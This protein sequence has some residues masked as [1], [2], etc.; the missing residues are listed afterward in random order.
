MADDDGAP[1]RK[2]VHIIGQ[3]L[4]DLSLEEFD[5][6]IALLK[7]EIERLTDARRIKAAAL[8][9]AGAFFRRPT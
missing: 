8:E 1:R 3:G 2:T 4:D 7:A 5:A 9:A 6:R